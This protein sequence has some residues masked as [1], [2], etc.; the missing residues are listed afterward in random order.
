MKA[1]S[2]V[3]LE[4]IR[5]TRVGVQ[6][7]ERLKKMILY[8]EYKI[9]E[10]LNIYDIANQLHVSRSP[11]KDAFSRLAQ[12]ELLEIKPNNG[13]FVKP[14]FLAEIGEVYECRAVLESW[15]AGQGIP[16]ISDDAIAELGHLI[17]AGR[18]TL[19]EARPNEF[20]FERFIEA[21]Y[22][23]HVGIVSSA[24]NG[25]LMKIYQLLHADMQ[26]TRITIVVGMSNLSEIVKAFSR[27][28]KEHEAIFGIVKCRDAKGAAQLLQ[29]HL[30]KE[31]AGTLEGLKKFGDRI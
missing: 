18:Q 12:E 8:R 19:A 5:H 3:Q 24:D 15:A 7:Y 1:D 21:G 16:A 29:Q 6:V 4:P 23:F 17:K 11:V 14:L 27:I 30:L 2:P 10:K 20:D 22:Q 9:G 28:Q 26:I 13:T 25:K 31:K